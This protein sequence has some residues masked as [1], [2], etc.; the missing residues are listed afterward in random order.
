[1]P[2]GLR[3][4]ALNIHKYRQQ[5]SRMIHNITINIPKAYNLEVFD[6]T[7]KVDSVVITEGEGMT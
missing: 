7:G 1:M 6:R 2:A 3:E 4:N 5:Q